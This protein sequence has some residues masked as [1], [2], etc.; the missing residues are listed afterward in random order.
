[1]Q[2]YRKCRKFLVVLWLVKIGHSGN[3]IGGKILFWFRRKSE[4]KNYYFFLSIPPNLS[5]H[6][7]AKTHFFEN[8][9]EAIPA[10]LLLCG[11]AIDFNFL[12]RV[13][14]VRNWF[15]DQDL[16]IFEFVDRFAEMLRTTYGKA[17]MVLKRPTKL[18]EL[19]FNQ[20]CA[21]GVGFWTSTILKYVQM[22]KF[23]KVLFF[24][25]KF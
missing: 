6:W 7:T 20:N 19:Q 18:F 3:L 12:P 13:F 24:V 8:C 21:K 5:I 17:T 22:R 4:K 2:K 11:F 25:A 10:M 1:M 14:A 23:I 9:R 16:W 15:A